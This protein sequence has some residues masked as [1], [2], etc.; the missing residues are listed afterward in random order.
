[1]IEFN[2]KKIQ[3]KYFNIASI[4]NKVNADKL[5]VSFLLEVENRMIDKYKEFTIAEV[6]DLIPRGTALVHNYAT[7]GFSIMSMFSGQKDRDYFV[8]NNDNL[9]DEFTDICN[10]NYNRDNYYW[11]KRYLNEKCRINPKYIKV[12]DDN[13]VAGKNEKNFEDFFSKKYGETLLKG[14]CVYR[15]NDNSVSIS[16]DNCI[17]FGDKKILI[18]IDSGNMAK[19]LVGQYI[20]LNELCNESKE[21]LFTVIHYYKAYNSQRTINNLSFVNKKVYHNKGIKFRVFNLNEF[22]SFCKANSTIE[23]LV[24]ELYK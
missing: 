3:S 1:M 17:D 10:N 21:V 20:L 8:F 2:W 23:K 5:F 7:Y 18:E 14:K 24:E 19:L 9:R 6:V 4:E 15:S 22:K 12:V 13:A 11:R 16:V